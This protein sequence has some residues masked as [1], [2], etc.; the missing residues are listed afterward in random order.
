MLLITA[1]PST[2]YSTNTIFRAPPE[3]ATGCSN[4]VQNHINLLLNAQMWVEGSRSLKTV[5]C[6]TL[7][8]FIRRN[9]EDTFDDDDDDDDDEDDDLKTL[10]QNLHSL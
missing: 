2:S 3:L 4:V 7:V 8:T 5:K 9:M 10:L 1:Y 6:D